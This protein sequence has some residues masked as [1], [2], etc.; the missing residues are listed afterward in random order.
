MCMTEQARE[1]MAVWLAVAALWFDA[2]PE[3]TGVLTGMLPA[4]PPIR[5]VE[6]A[7][8]A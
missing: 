1:D 2:A 5:W 7:A 3:L 6:A 8:E 4:G